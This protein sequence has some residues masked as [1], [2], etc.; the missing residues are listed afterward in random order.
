MIT[1]YKEFLR[2]TRTL[3]QNKK[4][5][6]RHWIRQEFER[7]KHIY[8]TEQIKYLYSTGKQQL[9]HVNKLIILSKDPKV[10]KNED[11]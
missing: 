5:E 4:K 3:E 2:Y 6:L 1:L 10:E 9:Q 11:E 8:D 7:N